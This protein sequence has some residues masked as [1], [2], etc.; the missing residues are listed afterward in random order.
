MLCMQAR[1]P[2]ASPTGFQDHSHAGRFQE[3]LRFLPAGRFQCQ[4]EESPHP[5]RE[6]DIDFTKLTQLQDLTGMSGEA[7]LL[8]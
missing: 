8:G 3:C 6:Q 4:L 7:V 2:T 1:L 5:H